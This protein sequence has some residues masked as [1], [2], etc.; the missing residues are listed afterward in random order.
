ML[1]RGWK[2]VACLASGPS[3][4]QAD[5]NLIRGRVDGVIA[6]NDAVRLAPWADVLY[7]QD[8]RWWKRFFKSGAAF[9]GPKYAIE[10]RPK[11][12]RE[13]YPWPDVTVL[14]NTGPHGFEHRPG[15]LKNYM[16]SGGAAINLAVHFGA[17][18]I[19]L[20]GYDMARGANGRHH[21]HG[22]VTPG[23]P[24][25]QFR[26]QIGTM[27]EPLRACGVTVLNCSRQT[28]LQCFPRVT[29]EQALALEAVA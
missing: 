24:Y 26:K 2:A 9:A 23:S 19:L 4:T 16:N 11:G 8:V 22:D 1:D 27:A 6:I 21:F 20:L 28:R 7:S 14:K 18:K 5:V 12:G 29:L 3:L 15:G 17:T 25:D 13:D 10:N